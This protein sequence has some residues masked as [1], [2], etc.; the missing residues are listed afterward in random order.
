[1]LAA[2]PHF[3]SY[4]T[5]SELGSI[6]IE[7]RK[8]LEKFGSEIRE[9]KVITDARSYIENGH[10]EIIAY[11]KLIEDKVTKAYGESGDLFSNI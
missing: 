2:S 5:S 8:C 9:H 3:V 1:M 10:E 4:V 7:T 11:K 6:L